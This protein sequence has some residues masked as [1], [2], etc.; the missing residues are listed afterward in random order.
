MKNLIHCIIDK[1][2]IANLSFTKK[3][4]LKKE[5]GLY[6]KLLNASILGNTY[7]SKV[8]IY[9]H[10]DEGPKQTTTTIWATCKEYILLKGGVW[11][12]ISKITNV[13]YNF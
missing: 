8:T 7:H 3:V 9:F 2:A 4:D 10:D 6:D 11:I 13:E 1:E 5:Q 12:P